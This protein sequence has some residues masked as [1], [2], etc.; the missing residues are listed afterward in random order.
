MLTSR[1]TILTSN[2]WNLLA[3][4]VLTGGAFSVWFQESPGGCG[5]YPQNFEVLFKGMGIGGAF[6]LLYCIIYPKIANASVA[7]PVL[8][9]V[10]RYFLAYT[11]LSYGYAKIFAGQ[12]PHT[13]VNMDARFVE[14]SPMRVAW[15][16]F[17]YSR[18]YQEFLGW[19][20][21]VPAVLL[22][23]RR[24]TLIGAIL[25]FIVM[26]NVF[27]VNIFF[28]VCVKLNSGI[29]TVLAFYIMLQSTSRLWT[30]FFTNR[31]AM[32]APVDNRNF[33][34]WAKITGMVLNYGMLLYILY[35]S[36]EGAYN[37]YQFSQTHVNASAVQGPWRTV[38]VKCWKDG[39]WRA[40]DQYDSLY[41]NRLFFDGA[42][43]VIKSD[44]IRDR[45]RF[46]IDSTGTA[47]DVRFTNLRN[48]WNI[49]PVTWKFERPATDS[50]KL[51][52]KWKSDS[53]MLNC[54]MR[55]EILTRY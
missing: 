51:W 47:M 50:L 41:A 27:L 29:Y 54:V 34:K 22:L 30:F 20:E 26:L 39:A 23:F 19:A 15:A 35:L 40:K 49:P 24:T 38:E 17:G 52:V 18:G 8:L 55:K 45:F 46:T 21:V 31:V 13:M 36:V 2:F 4:F 25:M 6:F 48:E 12:F 1:P 5:D 37:Y 33:P 44:H 11:I 16:F 7:Q 14:L 9:T 53:L 10:I 42:N 3:G 43:G 28:D 32:P